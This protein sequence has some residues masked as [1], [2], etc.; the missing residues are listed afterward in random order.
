MM[1][2]EAEWQR[3]VQIVDEIREESVVLTGWRNKDDVCP[4]MD[5]T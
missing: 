3:I 5:E 2:E 1:S 4:V